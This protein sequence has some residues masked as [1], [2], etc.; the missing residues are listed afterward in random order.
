MNKTFITKITR[1]IIPFIFFLILYTFVS[2]LYLFLDTALFPLWGNFLRP[3]ILP[4]PQKIFEKFVK[5]TITDNYLTF[6][7][8]ISLVRVIISLCIGVPIGIII[9]LFM[10]WSEKLGDYIDPLYGLIRYIPPL[11]FVTLFILWLG[12]SELSRILLITYSVIMVTILPT[13]HGIRDVPEKYVKAARIFGAKQWILL[14]NVVIPAASPQILAGL[15]YSIAVAWAV[16]IASE[17]IAATNGIGY[18]IVYAQ[19]LFDTAT[20]FLGI[21]CLFII[22]F[23][24]DN[25]VKEII[26]K[27]TSWMKRAE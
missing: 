19:R 7:V 20:I 10:G 4:P 5:Y 17:M 21:M 3:S 16:L 24:M 9:G 11:S 23:L 2:N 8:I 1:R 27:T 22:G 6:S 14:K 15:R 13:Y 18:M 12:I 26:F 25:I